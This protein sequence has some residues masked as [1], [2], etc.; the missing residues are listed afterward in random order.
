MATRVGAI[1][2]WFSLAPCHLRGRVTQQMSR[3]WLWMCY[4]FVRVSHS[5]ES[6]ECACRV[7]RH[8]LARARRGLATRRERARET[9]E[10]RAKSWVKSA[11][12]QK[13]QTLKIHL[14][15]HND[16]AVLGIFKFAPSFLLFISIWQYLWLYKLTICAP[17]PLPPLLHWFF[18]YLTFHWSD[19]QKVLDNDMNQDVI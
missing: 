7:R 8:R 6:P 11:R 17:K 3:F 10:E 13:A 9:A 5:W 12:Q 14:L 2:T 18:L 19:E 4:I 1:L 15:I 16:A